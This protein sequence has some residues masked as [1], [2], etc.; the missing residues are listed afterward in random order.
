M[1]TI[2]VGDVLTKIKQ[3]ADL[4]KSG[5][6][7]FASD[8]EI[9][10]LI[11]LGVSQLQNLV[12]DS[13]EYWISRYVTFTTVINQLT[14]PFASIG[15]GDMYKPLAIGLTSNTSSTQDTWTPLEQFDLMDMNLGGGGFFQF[16]NGAFTDMR[17]KF[18]GQALEFRPVKAAQLVGVYYVPQAP[19]FASTKDVLPSWIQR[20][21]EEY[22]VAFAA[23][24]LG[25]KEQTGIDSRKEVWALI[26]DQ[27][28]NF[29]PN[30]DRFRPH[31][32][33]RVLNPPTY[34]GN[35]GGWNGLY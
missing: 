10:G 25:I 23:W 4:E 2:T 29:A 5:A 7:G 19:Q 12:V 32:V 33:T 15:L 20:G 17:Y 22:P 14:Y 13:D 18:L 27:I 3:R 6:Q 8:S 11:Q 24:M 28:K 9:I 35:G 21:W 16:T 31:T 30:R 26:A 34:G 1:S